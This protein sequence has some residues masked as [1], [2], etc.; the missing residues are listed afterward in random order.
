M[1]INNDKYE[2]VIADEASLININ[3]TLKDKGKE[4]LYL[5]YPTDGV[6][7]NDSTFGFISNEPSKEEMFLKIQNYLLSDEGQK[8]L[9]NVGRRTWYGGVSASAPENIFRKEWGIDTTKYLSVTKFPSKNVISKAISLYI[10]IIRKPTHVVFCLDYS[11]SMY[12]N[13][14]EELKNAMTYILGEEAKKDNLQFSKKDKI[15]IIPFESNVGTPF[16][17]TGDNAFELITK[18]ANY[19]TGGLTNLYGAIEKGLGI[20]ND[21]EDTYTKTIIAMT[22]GAVNVG[23]F[24]DLSSYYKRL[25]KDIP[26]YS[27]T[28]GNALED[29]LEDIA[30]LTNAKVFDGKIN[31]LNAFKEV[32]GYN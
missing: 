15:T 22:D 8:M 28:F 14:I 24:Y 25:N 27:I 18:I 19:K 12:G 7:I 32:R 3:K 13:G 31:L 4:E 5:L 23:S 11:G 16:S 9:L 21:E 2:A 30:S 29:E 10:E 20:L 26:V 17:A 6:A 1:F